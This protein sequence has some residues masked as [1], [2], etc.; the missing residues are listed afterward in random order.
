MRILS[1]SHT[2]FHTKT[3]TAGKMKIETDSLDLHVHFILNKKQ[4][5]NSKAMFN[6]FLLNAVIYQRFPGN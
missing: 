2:L 5:S 4:M 1:L 3:L 6:P